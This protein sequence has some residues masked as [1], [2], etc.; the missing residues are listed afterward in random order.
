MHIR[1]VSISGIRSIRTLEWKLSGNEASQGW[2]VVIG[3]NGSGK[4]TFLRSIALAL[5]GP[6]EPGAL[7]QNWASWLPPSA[8]TAGSIRVTISHDAKWDPW[9]ERGRT[10]AS[11]LNPTVGIQPEKALDPDTSFTALTFSKNSSLKR[12]VWNP[13]MAGWFSAS[14]G[15]FRRFEGGDDSSKQFYASPRVG[16]HLSVF[17]ENVALTECLTWLRKLKHR[18]LEVN[19]ADR[20][21]DQVKHFVNKTGLLP[22]KTELTDVSADLVM[23]TDGNGCTIPI[24]SLGDGF[25]SVLSMTFELIRQLQDVYSSDRVFSPD[26]LKIE[27]PGVVMI[28]EVD[29]HLHP[30]WQRQIGS[31]FITHFPN[32][33]FIVTTHSPLVCWSADQGSIFRLPAQGSSEEPGM[34]TGDDK[35]RL[36]NGNVLD[37]YGTELFGTD[38]SRSASAHD[39]L[40]R[41]AELNRDRL[42]RELNPEEAAEYARLRD[43]LPASAYSGIAQKS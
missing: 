28:D 15:P 19:A 8:I 12:S 41:L 20:F 4:T 1:T 33:Q 29:A 43:E 35:K 18:Q 31:W 16:R 23:F 21:F 36:V 13:R 6:S 14:Y 3:D 42:E 38:V 17:G 32:M 27:P 24:E 34:V 39:K 40:T 26:G 5:I 7:R 25:R 30:T 9:S 2:H 22:A 37:A 10:S 11:T